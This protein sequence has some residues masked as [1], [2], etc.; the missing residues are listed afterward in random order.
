VLSHPAAA[1]PRSGP[2]LTT[3]PGL[4][5]MSS[6]VVTSTTSRRTSAVHLPPLTVER[7]GTRA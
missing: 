6:A 2:E 3:I 1:G 5:R 4:P 7:I